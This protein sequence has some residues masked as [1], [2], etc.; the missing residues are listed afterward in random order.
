MAP[1]MMNLVNIVLLFM[2]FQDSQ[3]IKG[4]VW[5][6][7]SITLCKSIFLFLMQLLTRFKYTITVWMSV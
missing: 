3:E 7:R 2:A 1:I 5:P 6:I 4:S